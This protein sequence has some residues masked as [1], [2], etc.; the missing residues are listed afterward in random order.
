MSKNFEF[1]QV[2]Y[3]KRTS[4]SSY[5]LTYCV[6]E[7][8]EFLSNDCIYITHFHASVLQHLFLASN[9]TMCQH[10]TICSRYC[11]VQFVWATQQNYMNNRLNIMVITTTNCMQIIQFHAALVIC[12]ASITICIAALA[13]CFWRYLPKQ[14]SLF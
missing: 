5:S 14:H 2:L 1:L 9:T 12:N 4:L 10:L 8:W 6:L 11:H 13:P 3:K 7:C